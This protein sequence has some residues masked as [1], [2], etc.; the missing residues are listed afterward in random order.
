MKPKL[1]KLHLLYYGLI[2]ASVSLTSTAITKWG[3]TTPQKEGVTIFVD[4]LCVVIT[5]ILW[6]K[7]IRKDQV[8]NTKIKFG[9]LFAMWIA[10]VIGV[11]CT[12]LLQRAD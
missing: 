4:L 3:K 12:L 5:H 7:Y 8:V 10:L 6:F 1:F 11:G 9:T 2:G